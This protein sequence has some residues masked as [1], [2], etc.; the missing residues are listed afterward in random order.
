[1]ENSFNLKYEIP[2]PY[3]YKPKKMLCFFGYLAYMGMDIFKK[4]LFFLAI[5]LIWVWKFSKKM[6]FFWLFGLYGSWLIWVWI[7]YS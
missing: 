7:R 5:W 2:N 6:L 3:P 1:M 4:M